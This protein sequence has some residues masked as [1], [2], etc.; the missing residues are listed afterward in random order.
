[1]KAKYD[2]A[3]RATKRRMAL[4]SVL[5]DE[6]WKP[7][8]DFLVINKLSWTASNMTWF[9][10]DYSCFDPD[11][12]LADVQS[13]QWDNVF[14]ENEMFD[15]FYSVVNATIDKHAPLKKLSK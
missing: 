3:S 2:G 15:S 1:M 13:I 9:A 8:R 11:N 5:R 14:R 6:L 12:F 7:K 4:C 10:R